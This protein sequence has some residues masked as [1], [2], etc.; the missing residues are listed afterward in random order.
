M[1]TPG[2][3]ASDNDTVVI[4]KVLDEKNQTVTVSNDELVAL[5]QSAKTVRTL[6]L[7]NSIYMNMFDYSIS[8]QINEQPYEIL[9]GNETYVYK[10]G[11]TFMRRITNWSD[12]KDVIKN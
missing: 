8:L 1:L 10:V 9:C 11:D 2:N 7:T 3:L 5:V 4:A 6:K 12:F